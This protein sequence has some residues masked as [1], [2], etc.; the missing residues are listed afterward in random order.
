MSRCL[1]SRIGSRPVKKL[2]RAAIAA[3]AFTMKVPSQGAEMHPNV[4]NTRIRALTGRAPVENVV[5]LQNNSVLG[6]AAICTLSESRD[7]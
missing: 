1:A 7:C 2:R 6:L 5:V 3:P 4:V